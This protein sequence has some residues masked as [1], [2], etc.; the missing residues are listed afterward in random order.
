MLVISIFGKLIVDCGL[1]MWGK[2]MIPM[3]R[4]WLHG[5]YGLH[6]PRCPLSPER[7][8]NWITHSLTLANWRQTIIGTMDWI[9]YWCICVSHGFE[10]D[11]SIFFKIQLSSCKCMFTVDML[12]FCCEKIQLRWNF[13]SIAPTH[14]R[15]FDNKVHGLN[16]WKGSDIMKL[17]YRSYLI[18]FADIISQ[19]AKIIGSTTIKHRSDTSASDRC[20]IDVDPKVF[21]LW[22]SC[23]IALKWQNTVCPKTLYSLVCALCSVVVML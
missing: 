13:I 3:Y 9:V 1:S 2:I 14:L 22:A 12:Q 10:Y 20:L 6:G 15:L 23:S 21:V 19:I 17:H 7:P 8:L 11:I 16:L 5:L 18:N 4:R